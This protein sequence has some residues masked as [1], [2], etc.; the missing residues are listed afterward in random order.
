MIVSLWLQIAVMQKEL[1]ELQPRLIETS[2]ETDELIIVIE[3]ET[4]EVEQVKGVVEADEAIANKAAMEAKAIK[5][6]GFIV[7][8]GF[9]FLV[10]MQGFP[11]PRRGNKMIIC[12]ILWPNPTT[13]KFAPFRPP[14]PLRDES[15]KTE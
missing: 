9:I 1:Q 13:L 15:G 4:A 5:V 2:R 8:Q 11:P 6:Q 12:K 7:V 3:K 14:P 10:A